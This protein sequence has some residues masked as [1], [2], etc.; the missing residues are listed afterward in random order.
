MLIFALSIITKMNIT[1]LIKQQSSSESTELHSRTYSVWLTNFIWS[2]NASRVSEC[3][4][5]TASVRHIVWTTP[6][7]WDVWATFH[8]CVIHKAASA[9]A[10]TYTSPAAHYNEL[11]IITHNCSV[12]TSQ[13]QVWSN[14][15]VSKDS[16]PEQ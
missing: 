16:S 13:Q 5:S 14:Y 15:T 10:K 3:N 11:V 6:A 2:F 9:F 7:I 1:L 8:N 4:V 12:L